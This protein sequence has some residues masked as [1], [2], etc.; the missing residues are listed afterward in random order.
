MKRLLTVLCLFWGAAAFGQG[1][2][3]TKTMTP[4]EQELAGLGKLTP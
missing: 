1:G 2:D 3:F 4:G